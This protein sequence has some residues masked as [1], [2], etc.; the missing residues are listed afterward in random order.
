MRHK[1]KAILGASDNV[2]L[3]CSL[4]DMIRNTY[5]VVYDIVYNIVYCIPYTIS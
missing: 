4:S 3:I 5:Y 2:L 1:W